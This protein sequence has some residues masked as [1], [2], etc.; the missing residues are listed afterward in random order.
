MDL[1]GPERPFSVVADVGAIPLELALSGEVPAQLLQGFGWRLA[2]ANAVSRPPEL[3]S[4]SGPVHSA[5]GAWPR[6]PASGWFSCRSACYLALG[7]PAVVQ[8]CGFGDAIPTGDVVLSF[9]TLAEAA[10]RIEN[11]ASAP[12]RHARARQAR[13]SGSTSTPTGPHPAARRRLRPRVSGRTR[14]A[15]AAPAPRALKGPCRSPRRNAAAGDETSLIQLPDAF[16][17]KPSV[18]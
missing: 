16:G 1:S 12:C 2:D 4:L 9:S 18:D 6:T 5:S 13:S 17:M 3:P 11:L 14:S 7:V 8:D 10:G 15:R